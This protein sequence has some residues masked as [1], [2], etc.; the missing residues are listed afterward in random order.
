MTSRADA[1]T[2]FTSRP[3]SAA[4]ARLEGPPGPQ[5][6]R[7]SSVSSTVDVHSRRRLPGLCRRCAGRVVGRAEAGGHRKTQN[8]TAALR[9]AARK[10]PA[11]NLAGEGADVD[12]RV[13][14]FPQLLVENPS[15]KRSTPIKVRLSAEAHLQGDD[16]QTVASGT[17]P[18]ATKRRC[19]PRSPRRRYLSQC[20]G[21]T[22]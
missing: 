2:S 13:V 5:P 19:R 1:I 10:G 22:R 8:S 17:G 7:P 14:E 21:S 18:R 6:L 3:R 15:A 4:R 12:A 16:V 20:T 9:P 11:E